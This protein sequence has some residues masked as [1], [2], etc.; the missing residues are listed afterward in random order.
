VVADVHETDVVP[1]DWLDTF[2]DEPETDATEPDATGRLLGAVVVELLDEPCVG[3]PDDALLQA[4]VSKA[5]EVTTRVNPRTRRRADD[6][7][8]FDNDSCM[9][10]PL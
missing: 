8:G 7:S 3:E 5:N 2:I 4:A 1:V 10:P 9:V 6:V